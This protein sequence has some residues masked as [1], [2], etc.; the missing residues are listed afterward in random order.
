MFL[1]EYKALGVEFWGL[2]AQN[3]P[4]DGLVPG[5]FFNCMGWTSDQQRLWVRRAVA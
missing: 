1:E 5:F 2:T 4:I 3:E